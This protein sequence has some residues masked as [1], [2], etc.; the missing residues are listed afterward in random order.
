MPRSFNHDL[1]VVLP[2][3]PGQFAERFQFGKLRLVVRIGDGARPE[4]VAE[5]EGHVIGFHDLANLLEV[6]VREVF[7]MVRQAPLG[8]DGAAA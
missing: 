4:A 3:D 8:V 5:A 2:G 6:L 1:H 7:F